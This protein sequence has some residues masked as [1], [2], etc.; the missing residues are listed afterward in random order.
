MDLGE[1]WQENKRFVLGVGIGA[2]VFFLAFVMVRSSFED[3]IHSRRREISQ[4]RSDLELAMFD[5]SDLADA[6]LENEA[7]REAVARLSEST[8]FASRPGFTLESGHGA[9]NAQYLRILARVREDL[10]RRANR[11][12]L[13]LDASLGMPSLSPTREVE[14]ERYLE[15]LDVVERLVDLALRASVQRVEKIRIQLDAGL[16][17]RE[18]LGSVERT[19]VSFTVTGDSLALTRILTWARRPVS[20][21]VLHVEGIEISPSRSKADE[22]RMELTLVIAR[23]VED[24]EAA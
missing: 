1:Y 19:R 13:E 23:L 3:D 5:A 24:R 21:G 11:S 4:R 15:A 18:G 8:R 9:P 22:V 12:N 6:R 2:L 17:S 16:R 20:G 14:I 7:L 10:L